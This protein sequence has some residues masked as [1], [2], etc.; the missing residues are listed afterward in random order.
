MNQK[1][2]EKIKID[3][4]KSLELQ[5]STMDYSKKSRNEL[6]AICREKSLKGYSGKKKDEIVKLLLTED[7]IEK[8]KMKVASSVN[9]ISEKLKMI[10]LFAGTGAFTLAFQATNAV[11]IVFG[12][13]MVEHS[14]KIYDENFNHKLTLEN[15]NNVKVE[16]IPKHD[17]LTGGFPCFIEGT[18]TLT[19]NG[20]KNIENVEIT[21]KLLTH[22]GKFQKIT[23]LQRKIYTG[24]LFDIKIKYHPE[25][26]TSTEEHP[27]YVREK[28]G[29]NNFGNPIWKKANELTMNDYFGMVINNNEIIPEFTFEKSIN[30]HKREKQH[31]KLDTLDYW[32]VMGYLVG[33]GWIE[34][35]TKPD[36]RCMYKIRFA[37][38]CKDGDEIF[39]RINKVIPISDKKCN[40]GDK[41]K[42]FG[43]SNIIWYSIL[44]QF[45]KYAHEKL[46]PEW[47][48]DAPKEFIQEFI[49]GY[50]K[51]H[52]CI[53]NNKILQ[54][55][56]VS[57]NLAYGLQRLYLKLGHIFSINKCVRPKTTIIEGRTVNQRDTYCIR[58]IL[59]RQ[60]K[61]AS[62]IEDNYIWFVPSKIVKREITQIPVYNFE[63]ENDNSYIVMNTIVHNC[64]PFS[65]AGHQEGFNDERANVFWK[66][67][68][69]IDYHQPKC[70]LLENVKNLVSHDENKTFDIIKSNLEKRGYHICFKVLNTSDI[71]GIPQHRERIYIVCMKSKKVF[72]KFNLD[73]PKI[74]KKA[75]SNFLE[76]NVPDKYYYSDKSTTWNV[77]KSSVVKKDTF[78][79]YRRVYVR[80]NKSSE[81]PT[82]TANMGGGG[83]NVPIILDDKGIRKLTPRECFNLQGFPSSYK[84]PNISDS[85]LY[86]LAGNAV[87]VPVVNLI[88]NR[89]IPL[90]KEDTK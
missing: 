10:D 46:I 30:Q 83:H 12:N 64:Q 44:K 31:I 36:G 82:L 70:V 1:R 28:K 71:T 45:G 27:F 7:N 47:V 68:S 13:D 11:N 9:T 6:I 40:T 58:G 55:T 29:I 88:A 4:T 86:K 20:Y 67:L 80:E 15:L 3:F 8:N 50:M 25:I 18:P 21:D 54:I 87:S 41:C 33:D 78:Y 77:V 66:I 51:A 16:D 75:I 5:S 81:C 17:I 49:N 26:V 61:I 53:N 62:F 76:T 43:C 65:I 38:N 73:F 89:I 14:K 22:N 48:Q 90:L 69:I 24:N 37:I 72:E 74:E 85:S 63:V 42:K 60:R 52:G 19:N 35:T 57:S 59:Q 34:E 39:E 79:Q 23:N 2:Y 84:L 32:F 56:T